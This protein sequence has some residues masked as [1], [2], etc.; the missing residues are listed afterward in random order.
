MGL[1]EVERG[2]ERGLMGLSMGM[3]MGRLGGQG[4]ARGLIMFWWQARSG[5]LLESGEL[6]LGWQ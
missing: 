4:G 6:R 3:E 1:M 5:C 2:M